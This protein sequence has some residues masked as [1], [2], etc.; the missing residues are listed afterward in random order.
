MRQGRAKS[1]TMHT[2]TRRRCVLEPPPGDPELSLGLFP[3]DDPPVDGAEPNQPRGR[4]WRRQW[5]PVR[6]IP[7]RRG[8]LLADLSDRHLQRRVSHRLAGA[9]HQRDSAS[10]DLLAPVLE[11][12]RERWQRVGLQPH[13]WQE[14]PLQRLEGMNE[15]MR[16]GAAGENPL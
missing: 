11:K 8:A 5:G 14:Q 9:A 15:E 12:W 4:H 7:E 1:N 16:R 6:C 2:E 13:G 10:A 3:R